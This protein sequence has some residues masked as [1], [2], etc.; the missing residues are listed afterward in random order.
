MKVKKS[1]FEIKTRFSDKVIDIILSRY[2]KR[3]VRNNKHEKKTA[4]AV[5]FRSKN[6]IRSIRSLS[7]IVVGKNLHNRVEVT[8]FCF[9]VAEE[10][11]YKIPYS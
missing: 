10:D 1:F 8:L 9:F 2:A 3:S 6:Q 7:Y 5:F 4:K 11:V